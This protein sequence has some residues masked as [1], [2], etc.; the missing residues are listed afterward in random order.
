[1]A[2]NGFHLTPEGPK[3]CRAS[4]GNC[5]YAHFESLTNARIAFHNESEA[6]KKDAE[7]SALQKKALEWQGPGVLSIGFN[8]PILRSDGAGRKFD[9]YS[10]RHSNK[11]GVESSLVRINNEFKLQ[12]NS[13]EKT[14]IFRVKRLPKVDG[15]IVKIKGEWTVEWWDEKGWEGRGEPATNALT[16]AGRPPAEYESFTFDLSNET[17]TNS[18]EWQLYEKL[19]KTFVD[20]SAF[21]GENKLHDTRPYDE[22]REER[23][24]RIREFSYRFTDLM[25]AVENESMGPHQAALHGLGYYE[26]YP[27][28]NQG[29]KLK[30]SQSYENCGFSGRTMI[31]L[32]NDKEAVRFGPSPSRRDA[33]IRVWSEQTPDS[34][35]WSVEYDPTQG[36]IVDTF[37][38]EDGGKGLRY[39]VQNGEEAKS[40]IYHWNESR[41]GTDYANVHDGK[42]GG[43]V[44]ELVD[45]T[46]RAFDIISKQFQSFEEEAQQRQAERQR[47]VFLSEDEKANKSGFSNLF[48][49]FSR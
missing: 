28:A 17:K 11:N 38:A 35:S 1:M 7:K 45:Q 34:S 19:S 43:Y 49:I 39:K 6:N 10:R 9:I 40:V 48:D 30:I 13:R 29:G 42:E 3:P 24:K 22:I 16:K 4:K 5:P 33:S 8:D 37:N 41:W 36:W 31:A 21:Q 14:Y 20:H 44:H 2:K 15:D 18:S 12:G 32:A 27:N 46:N 47:D 26:P 23:E 25:R